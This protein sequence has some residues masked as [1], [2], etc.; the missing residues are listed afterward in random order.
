MYSKT[1][2]YKKEMKQKVQQ[3]ILLKN[4]HNLTIEGGKY[5]FN[6]YYRFIKTFPNGSN[7]GRRSGCGSDP[8]RFFQ[9]TNNLTIE[10]STTLLADR[11][12][13]VKFEFVAKEPKDVFMREYEK[14]LAQSKK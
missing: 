3:L 6:I 12:D 5:L 13:V 8:R 4:Y 1:V 10:L 7:V 14:A 2:K 9:I 11:G